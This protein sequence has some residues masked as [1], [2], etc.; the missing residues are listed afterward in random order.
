MDWSDRQKPARAYVGGPARVRIIESGPARVALE[1]TRESEGSVFVQ[2]IRLAAGDAGHRLE[3]ATRVDWNTRQASLRA[4][5]PLTVA[6]PF[7][8]YDSQL[9]TVARD[10]NNP[11]KFEHPQHQWFDLT[12]TKGDYGVAVLNDSKYG[13][14]KPDDSTVRL[15]LLHTPGWR[16]GQTR[17]QETQDLGRHDV[18]F[19]LAGHRGDWAAAG[20]S[21]EAA[22]LNQPLIPF[23][24]PAH[25]GPLGRA[26]SLLSLNTD[27]VEVV[28]VKLAEDNDELIVRVRELTG[29]PA[30]SVRLAVRGEVTA[31]RE[32][33]GQE[34]ALA[35]AKL[36]SGA[37]VFDLTPYALKAFSIKLGKPAASVAPVASQPVPLAYDLDVASTDKNRADGDFD[38]HGATY[39]AEQLPSTL[40]RE[41]V[42]F[43]FGPT[44]DGAKNALVARGQ[45]LALPAGYNRVYLLASSADGDR[46]ATLRI[47]D[48]TASFTVQPWN[49][50]IG[51]WDNRLWA[52]KPGAVDYIFDIPMTGLVP[53]FIK[54]A[55]VAW[56]ATHYH[57][58]ADNTFYRF[59]Y[60]F[61]H[62]FDVP[63]G[64]TTLTL[65][66]DD[67]IRILAVSVA[68]EP[69]AGVAPAAPLFDTLTAPAT[70]TPATPTVP[71]AG[72]KFSDLTAI[73]IQP[74]L[75][76]RPGDLRYTLDGSEPVAASP[77]YT[78]PLEINRPLTLKVRQILPD[79]TPGPVIAAP[80]LVKDVTPPSV[81]DATSLRDRVEILFS[82]PLDAAT[83]QNPANY[84]FTTPVGI[85]SASLSPDARKVTLLLENPAAAA[86]ALTLALRGLRD[87]APAANVFATT[88]VPVAP[89]EVYRLAAARLPSD[90]S[91]TPVA[92][93]PLKASQP[94]TLH[95]FAKISRRSGTTYL[96]GFGTAPERV[97]R[98]GHGRFLAV[99]Q[100]GI[101]F[102][103]NNRQNQTYSPLDRDRWQLLSAVYDGRAITLYKDARRIGS[104]PITLADDPT[105]EVLIAPNAAPGFEGE[106]R[107]VTILRSAATPNEIKAFLEANRPAE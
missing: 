67:H 32:V 7:A 52:R 65:P 9:G 86:T 6:N 29:K 97:D 63:P 61:Q 91:V 87:T 24:T 21:W 51:Q 36:D 49:G 102:I 28:A 43:Q 64:A 104:Q 101:C 2:Q 89:D 71:Q 33:D 14:D 38:G 13:S 74:P 84:R 18:L 83:A 79:G 105:G 95:L 31:A 42:T 96:A 53:G 15:T 12:D 47:G 73:T 72:Q 66:T 77:V 3:F 35:P 17:D 48:R 107:A 57:T 1:V 23:I 16:S 99:V 5:F 27:Q 34:H 68:R 50:F 103:A 56:F 85:R 106:L 39:P 8:V 40:T 37:L 11:K 69:G 88:S 80:L 58:P 4:A 76:Y 98:D 44:T 25:A 100:G 10:N 60:V 62:G 22:R 93:L 45:T 46:P 81:L 41:G 54:P 30:K 94:W 90:A 59:S 78:A 70:S 55:P 20:V 82:E 26:F 92:N 19:A 75:Y